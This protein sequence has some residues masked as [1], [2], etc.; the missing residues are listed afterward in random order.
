GQ[1]CIL[2][3]REAQDRPLAQ[4]A[5]IFYAGLL[6]CPPFDGFALPFRLILQKRT[7]FQSRFRKTVWGRQGA[8]SG[9]GFPSRPAERFG[10]SHRISGKVLT[11]MVSGVFAIS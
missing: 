9:S 10:P 2:S 6:G 5:L 11:C 7:S 4:P 1:P 8:I 3:R